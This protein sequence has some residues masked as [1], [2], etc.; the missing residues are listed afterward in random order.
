MSQERYI[1]STLTRFNMT[2]CSL[3][4]TLTDKG[5]QLHKTIDEEYQPFSVLKFSCRQAISS[6]IHFM[7]ATILY[8]IRAT[9]KLSQYLNKPSLSHIAATKLLFRYL[10]FLKS[11][12]ITFTR[13]NRTLTLSTDSDWA[14]DT[15]DHWSTS[16]FIDTLLM[17]R[18]S[19]GKHANNLQ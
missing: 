7:T 9:A 13:S 10:K 4:S 14:G 2:K 18:Q 6:L 16:S 5:T 8:I 11:N 15:T 19:A 17:G 3:V 12:C 1:K